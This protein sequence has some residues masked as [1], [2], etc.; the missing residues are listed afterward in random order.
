MAN[1]LNWFEIPVTDM[2]RA[3]KFYCAVMGYE[4]MFQMNMG[5]IDMAFFPRWP[6]AL[7]QKFSSGHL[8]E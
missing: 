8:D 7:A 4:S 3:V 6:F 1:V 5:G 2:A